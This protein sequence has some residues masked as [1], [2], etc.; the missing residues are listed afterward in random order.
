MP[1]RGGKSMAWSAL[2]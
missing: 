1:K 2:A